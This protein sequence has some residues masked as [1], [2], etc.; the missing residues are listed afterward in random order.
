MEIC[1]SHRRTDVFFL[2]MKITIS[3]PDVNFVK[4]SQDVFHIF[5]KK[6]FLKSFLIKRNSMW[7]R[8]LPIMKKMSRAIYSTN[9]P[10]SSSIKKTYTPQVKI[11]PDFSSECCSLTRQVELAKLKFTSK[12]ELEFLLKCLS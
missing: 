5:P 11:F 2:F 1:Q 7:R 12:L 3:L 10:Y 4:L 9:N 8:S 6:W